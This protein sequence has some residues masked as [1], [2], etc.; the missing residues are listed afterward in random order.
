MAYD[1]VREN[2][3]LFGGATLTN[4]VELNKTWIWNGTGWIRLSPANS[5]P[6]RAAHAMAFD[7]ARGDVVLF[8]GVVGGVASQDTWIWN[9]VTWTQ[10]FPV[11]VPPARFHAGMVFD[12]ALQKILL[13]GGTNGSPAGLVDNWAWDGTNWT[14]LA[15]LP[16]GRALFGLAYD[17]VRHETVVY[18]GENNSQLVSDTLTFDGT[19]WTHISGGPTP[20]RESDRMVF[21]TALG[22]TVLFG[23][24]GVT[25]LP[26]YGDTWIWDGASWTPAPLGSNPPPP[27][28]TS[29]TMA[30]DTAHSQVVLFGGYTAPATGPQAFP[31]DTWVYGAP[32]VGGCSQTGTLQVT[33]NLPSATFTITGPA[34]YTGSGTSFN[35]ADAPLGTYTITYGSVIGYVQPVQQT[36]TLTAGGT[37]SFAGTYNVLGIDLSAVPSLADWQAINSTY[38]PQFVVA[39]AWGGGP[40]IPPATAQDILSSIPSS[41]QVQEA[42]YAVLDYNSLSGAAQ[43][44]DAVQSIGGEQQVGKLAFIAIDVEP[45]HATE[46]FSNSAA[47][48]AARNQIIYDA[49]QAVQKS[50]TKAIIYTRQQNDVTPTLDDWFVITGNT[51]SF[52]CLPLWDAVPNG[53]KTLRPAA[54]LPYGNWTARTGKQYLTNQYALPSTTTGSAPVDLDV[55][56]PRVFMSTTLWGMAN[57]VTNSFPTIPNSPPYVTINP[58][59]LIYSATT[60]T[61][62]QTITVSNPTNTPIGGPISFVLDDL[63]GFTLVNPT[64][65]TSCTFPS[66]SV[67]A[68]ISSAGIAANSTLTTTLSFVGP[69]SGPPVTSPYVP[70]VLSGKG[71]R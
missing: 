26:L 14:P 38:N 3:V 35:Q 54:N 66:G 27:A 51:K 44:Q 20:L 29:H 69:A 34:T 59:D 5:P 36:E 1:S 52:G 31:A 56:Q 22:E 46:I 47:A 58:T 68:N 17:A 50:G 37:I 43:M 71:T 45:L 33:T 21:D 41:M 40:N 32:T 55:F 24:S 70:R 13:I 7:A 19:T 61:W 6:A 63:Q 18:G 12:T 10:K 2:V 62:E 60:Q 64:G 8:G 65:V 9:G 57:D 25:G 30:Y 42:A 16:V 53:I 67:Y 15:P 11:T 23:G 39:R 28:R 4:N 49:I 48:I